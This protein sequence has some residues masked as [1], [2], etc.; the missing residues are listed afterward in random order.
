MNVTAT[1]A[2]IQPT[3]PPLD[4]KFHSSKAGAAPEAIAPIPTPVATTAA[5]AV[6]DPNQL[7]GTNLDIAA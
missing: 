4:G 5:P 1:A 3:L 6:R 2:P 7:A